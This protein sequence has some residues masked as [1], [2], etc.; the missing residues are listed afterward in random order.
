MNI[1]LY[2]EAVTV[3]PRSQYAHADQRHVLSS[4]KI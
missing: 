2:T 1:D 3:L 4:R